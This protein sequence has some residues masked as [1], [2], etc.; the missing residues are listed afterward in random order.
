MVRNAL[1]SSGYKLDGYWYSWGTKPP[2][3]VDVGSI[4]LDPWRSEKF[5]S[6]ERFLWLNQLEGQ[7]IE[8]R[9]N[10]GRLY[11]M[12]VRFNKDNIIGI[13]KK[14]S[15]DKIFWLELGLFP[16]RKKSS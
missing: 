12:P 2:P 6:H 5:F 15:T 9:D 7:M 13:V 16:K 1:E 14:H 8:E 4:K 11:R 10:E 3:K